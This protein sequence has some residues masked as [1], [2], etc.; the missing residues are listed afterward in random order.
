[1]VVADSG[2]FVKEAP[3]LICHHVVHGVVTVENVAGFLNASVAIRAN[4]ERLG[5]GIGEA[6]WKSAKGQVRSKAPTTAIVSSSKKPAAVGVPPVSTAQLEAGFCGIAT[7]FMSLFHGVIADDPAS[8][9]SPVGLSCLFC[10]D[11]HP[12]SYVS[13]LFFVQDPRFWQGKSIS[14]GSPVVVK[15][16]PS[17]S[18]EMGALQMMCAEPDLGVVPVLAVAKNVCP[19]WHAIL[20][21]RLTTLSEFLACASEDKLRFGE[22]IVTGINRL[23]EARCCWLKN[24]VVVLL[25]HVLH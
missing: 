16:V 14:D 10:H 25:C 5:T 7:G 4:A 12:F 13:V 6:I 19:G 17:G 20:M 2:A 11:C 15:L 22:T 24:R 21:P 18:T 1:M 23:V 8:S 9:S 3:W